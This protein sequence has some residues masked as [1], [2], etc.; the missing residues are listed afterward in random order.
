[1]VAQLLAAAATLL[2][3]ATAERL[4]PAP[5]IRVP[6]A[7]RAEVYATGLPHPTA[8][9]FGPGGALYVAED[10]GRVV[11]VFPGR[12]PRVVADGIP[13]P[14]GLAWRGSHLY[15]SAQ[16]RLL[17]LTLRNGRVPR[18]R[19]TLYTEVPEERRAASFGAAPLAEPLNPPVKDARLKAPP[20]LVR[21][22]FAAV[23]AAR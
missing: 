8:M 17:R 21:P 12:R 18:Q 7:F 6:P 15:V 13:T 16:G 23:G 19:T 20:R 10:V 3:P 2:A 4:P 1:M 11:S 5:A 9:A 22:G 14:L